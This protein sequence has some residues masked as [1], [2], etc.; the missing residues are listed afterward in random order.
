MKSYK[1]DLIIQIRVIEY[2]FLVV[3]L[4]ALH[5]VTLASKLEISSTAFIWMQS[6]TSQRHP[7]TQR[8]EPPWSN[9]NSSIFLNAKPNF[10]ASSRN[11]KVRTTL[12]Q[13]EFQ[14]F[15]TNLCCSCSWS[16]KNDLLKSRGLNTSNWP[17]SDH[18][19]AMLQISLKLLWT[20]PR[21]WWRSSHTRYDACSTKSA[22]STV[23]QV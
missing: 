22:D 14:H 11:S 8:L 15:F 4:I 1:C 16:I 19:A 20:M 7:A 10:T 13:Q 23:F 12:K 5:K 18:E 21:L 9:R 3:L 2:Y 17:F 6:Q